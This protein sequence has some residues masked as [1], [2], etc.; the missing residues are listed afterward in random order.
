VAARLTGDGLALASG[1]PRTL[2]VGRFPWE[3]GYP[4]GVRGVG[5]IENP[6]MARHPATD[7]WLLTWSANRWETQ[8]YATGLAVCAGPLGPCDRVGDTPWVSTSSDPSVTTANRLGGA[9]GLSFATSPDGG[10]VAV[11]HAYPGAGEDPDARRMGWVFKVE[12]D[13]T[14][15]HGYRLVGMSTVS[16]SSG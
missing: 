3:E 2:M 9:G 4:R 5:P 14:S 11:L 15:S 13:P 7:D 12:A 8:A 10:L 6:A 16:A 1:S